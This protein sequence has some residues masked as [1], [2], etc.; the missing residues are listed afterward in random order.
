MKDQRKARPR[1]LTIGHDLIL[2][3]SG[4]DEA[5]PG[6]GQII[7]SDVAGTATVYRT[8]A[9]LIRAFAGHADAM[10]CGVTAQML[11]DVLAFYLDT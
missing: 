7:I 5:F 1:R 4:G 11:A 10:N 8:D 6:L 9:D 3:T 2:R